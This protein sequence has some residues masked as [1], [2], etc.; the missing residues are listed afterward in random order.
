MLLDDD[1]DEE[2]DPVKDDDDVTDT[3]TVVD[4]LPDKVTSTV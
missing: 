1:A 2:I 3:V 4:P